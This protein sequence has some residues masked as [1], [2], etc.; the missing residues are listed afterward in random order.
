MCAKK[1][2]IQQVEKVVREA[3]ISSDYRRAFGDYVEESKWGYPK[4]YTYS[5]KELLELAN[6]FIEVFI[7][8]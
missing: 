2:D 7:K 4:D 6:E 8:R 3:G 1:R 5:Y